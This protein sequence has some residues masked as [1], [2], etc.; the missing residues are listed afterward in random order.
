MTPHRRWSLVTVGLPGR[1]FR[2]QAEDLGS[3]DVGSPVYFRHVKADTR[4]WQ[5][6]G[7]D[8]ALD[9]SGIRLN[10][11]SVASLLLGGIAFQTPAESAQAP[12]AQEN[13]SFTLY[14]DRGRAMRLPDTAEETYFMVFHESVRG[15]SVGAP[16]DFRGVVV[17]E[18][19]SIGVDF[20]ASKADVRIPVEVRLYPDRLHGKAKRVA[21]PF[22]ALFGK[23]VARGLRAQLRIGSLLTGQLFVALDF[24]P[25][26]PKAAVLKRAGRA[27]IPTGAG[28]LQE[29]QASLLG[30]AH[31]L[32][33]LPLEALRALAGCA[34]PMRTRRYYTL[35]SGS[36]GVATTASV[37]PDYRVAIGPVT[38]PEA[39]DRLQIVLRVAPNRYAIS[40]TERW[41][42]P[43][44]REIP[45]VIANEVGQR[46]HAARVAAHLQH[47]GQNA[48]Y[49]VLIEVLRFES[50]PGASITLEAA[51]SVR[52]RAGVRRSPVLR[53][54]PVAKRRLHMLCRQLAKCHFA[55]RRLDRLLHPL[56]HRVDRLRR[57]QRRG[58]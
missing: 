28:S 22:G 11:E 27:E 45:R 57:R 20:D 2:L 35:S 25:G 31:K 16:V 43:L 26:E 3:L 8:A 30:L 50:M 18:V 52:N 12:P 29:L 33:K 39:L 10:T 58:R 9:A 14:A 37:V 32:G 34:T 56:E 44:K 13:V 40:D 1:Q 54:D 42:E 46:L 6:S 24:F 53:D 47:G 5:A 7:F 21:A 15:L 48:D 23:L 49:Q 38:V 41:L 36:P 19:T 51:W 17:G 4:F 55:E